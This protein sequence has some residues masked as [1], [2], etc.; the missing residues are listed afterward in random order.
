LNI[1]PVGEDKMEKEKQDK[2]KMTMVD[3]LEEVWA[4]AEFGLY[5]STQPDEVVLRL[6]EIVRSY[7]DELTKEESIELHE[8]LESRGL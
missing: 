8:K 3:L 6:K 2:F 7:T 1:I 5:E 4:T